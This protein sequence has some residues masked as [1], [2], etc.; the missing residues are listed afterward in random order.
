MLEFSY[1]SNFVLFLFTI[2]WTP[3]SWRLFWHNDGQPESNCFSQQNGINKSITWWTNF[4]GDKSL[5][6]G[7]TLLFGSAL[8]LV[9]SSFYYFYYFY[10]YYYYYYYYDFSFFGWGREGVTLTKVECTLSILWIYCKYASKVYLKYTLSILEECFIFQLNE[11]EIKMYTSSLYFV[12]LNHY[13]NV[14]LKYTSNI[15]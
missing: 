8:L 11:L 13:F 6:G 4:C 7:F 3:S 5:F 1:G 15:F 10:Y 2:S 14:N 12:K 9:T